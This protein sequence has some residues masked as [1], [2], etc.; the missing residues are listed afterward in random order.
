[1]K[2]PGIIVKL[3][4]NENDEVGDQQEKKVLSKLEEK[5]ASS[6]RVRFSVDTD[7]ASEKTK[8]FSNRKVPDVKEKSKC[9]KQQGWRYVR[10]TP[11]DSH[12]FGSPKAYAGGSTRSI[13]SQKKKDPSAIEHVKDLAL[14]VDR[15]KAMEARDDRKLA[16][17]ALEQLEAFGD[18]MRKQQEVV[19]DMRHSLSHEGAKDHARL[20]QFVDA[21]DRNIRSMS[22]S[23]KAKQT[24]SYAL[25]SRA[26]QINKLK[27]QCNLLELDREKLE[28]QLRHSAADA[29]GKEKEQEMSDK[30]ESDKV[31]LL[32]QKVKELESSV[33]VW[34]SKYE[35]AESDFA[36]EKALLEDNL[37]VSKLDWRS[38]QQKLSF[39]LKERETELSHQKV[40]QDKI[41]ESL[42]SCRLCMN[43]LRKETI[44][45]SRETIGHGQDLDGQADDVLLKSTDDKDVLNLVCGIEKDIESIRQVLIES[46]EFKR[47]PP[48]QT[49]TLRQETEKV[50]DKIERTISLMTEIKQEIKVKEDKFKKE[51]EKYMELVAEKLKLVDAL[52]KQLA[53]KERDIEGYIQELKDKVNILNQELEHEQSERNR[54]SE[55]QR[56]M[57]YKL[58]KG[59]RKK[60]QKLE[61]EIEGMKEKLE[62][63]K[64]TLIQKDERLASLEDEV[65]AKCAQLVQEKQKWNMAMKEVKHKAAKRFLRF[66]HEKENGLLEHLR[67]RKSCLKLQEGRV[68]LSFRT[69]GS[70]DDEDDD[71]DEYNNG[72]CKKSWAEQRKLSRKILRDK[73]HS[74]KLEAS[75]M[76]NKLESPRDRQCFSSRTLDE[77]ADLRSSFESYKEKTKHDYGLSRNRGSLR[78]I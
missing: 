54:L 6:S 2:V 21:L 78:D 30:I 58:M 50:D 16:I 71:D 42:V 35:K 72:D 27:A 4:E 61:E 9:G 32:E 5:A 1:M 38:K 26:E 37:Q 67:E 23:S 66:M 53:D 73:V 19:T 52:E 62:E 15:N 60:E 14:T 55:Q 28:K 51:N 69:E 59:L 29:D 31:N 64:T 70:D 43:N 18:F 7:S 11:G 47:G 25:K 36:A 45:Y 10:S 34:K 20:R 63:M 13:G 46:S 65:K 24:Q 17:L 22:S 49:E 56:I 8:G 3:D 77:I 41:I 12:G 44:A 48:I 57:R 74:K 76:S 75:L 68:G 33:A 39:K 40:Y